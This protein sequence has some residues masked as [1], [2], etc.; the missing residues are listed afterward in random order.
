MKWINKLFKLYYENNHI[1]LFVLGL[2]FKKRFSL[3]L[4]QQ[5]AKYKDEIK[6]L[7]QLDNF[8][9]FCW[10]NLIKDK[11]NTEVILQSFDGYIIN[12]PDI[13]L[14][15]KYLKY[16][17]VNFDKICRENNIKYW[18]RGGTL[19]GAIRHKGFIPWD[20][21]IDIGIM[22]NDLQRLV[23]VCKKTTFEI[24]YYYNT[25]V[26]EDVSRMPRFVNKNNG[27][28]IF[29]DLFPFDYTDQIEK[30][31]IA[32]YKNNRLSIYNDISNLVKEKKIGTYLGLMYED[33][34]NDQNIIEQSF[35]KYINHNQ[36]QTENIIYPWDW[37]STTQNLYY[38]T[39]DIFPLKE[40]NFQNNLLTYIPNNYELALNMCYT[41]YLDFP[42]KFEEHKDLHKLLSDKNHIKKFLL[43]EFE[44]TGLYNQ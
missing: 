7:K 37:F 19:L 10:H 38:K 33:Y 31:A 41:N 42:S 25:T 20:D 24:K 30:N 35:D 18:L 3:I 43:R 12:N 40:I 9:T 26:P 23:D 39:K 8:K 29:I 17:L 14:I 34:K 16:L 5:I 27:I 32:T 36:I 4:E 6:N 15:Q 13:T 21:D 11:K 22:R 1:I 28:N 44:E 2:K